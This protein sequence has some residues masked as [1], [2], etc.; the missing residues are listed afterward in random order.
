MKIKF[1]GREVFLSLIGISLICLIFVGSLLND[2]VVSQNRDKMPVLTQIQKETETH[3]AFQNNNQINYPYLSDRF[4]LG[5]YIYSLGDFLIYG[6]FWL[7]VGFL[8]V[9]C[10]GYWNYRKKSKK[11]FYRK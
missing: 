2:L 3:F 8:I 6:A 11:R 10:V 1:T 4:R 9:I 7:L 5:G